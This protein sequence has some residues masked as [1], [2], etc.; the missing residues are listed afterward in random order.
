MAYNAVPTL[1][2]GDIWS[3]ANANTY[4]RD[5][6]AA[7]VPDIFTAAGDIAIA[8]AAN[9]ASPLAIGSVGKALI[10]SS[11]GLPAWGDI[12]GISYRQG[13]SATDWGL[14]TV[15][16]TDTGSSDNYTVTSSL[17][18]AG[19]LSITILDGQSS[20]NGYIYFPHA[21]SGIPIV[22]V[23]LQSVNGATNPV[24]IRSSYSTATTDYAIA[25][26]YSG[27]AVSGDKT[28]YIAWLAIG[29]P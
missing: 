19:S 13:G 18:Q 22:L 3:A 26:I 29:A 6:F 16:S 25:T 24:S 5:N 15:G 12:P 8:T 27:A 28:N 20:A 2:T 10:S 17:V 11:D 9:A 7:G 21:F 23:S 1:T 14:G 4:W